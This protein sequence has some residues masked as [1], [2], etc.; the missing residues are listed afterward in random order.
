[1][2]RIVYMV[3]RNCYKVPIWFYQLCRLSKPSDTHTEEERYGF[4]KNIVT[5]VNKTGR[6]TV[7]CFGIEHIP[8]QDGFIMFPDR[9]S[10]V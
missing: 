10:V 5:K 2:N 4:L 6:V 9:K 3:L 8:K 1:M 7:K